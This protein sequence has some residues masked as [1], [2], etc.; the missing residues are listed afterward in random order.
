[1]DDSVPVTVLEFFIYITET[2][3]ISTAGLIQ[4]GSGGEK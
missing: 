1:M 4:E 3:L 2:G